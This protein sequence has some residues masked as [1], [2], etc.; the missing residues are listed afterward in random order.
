MR[1]LL[2][3]DDVPSYLDPGAKEMLSR[4]R[5]TAREAEL[6]RCSFIQDGAHLTWFTWTGTRIHHTLIAI[7]IQLRRF[8]VQNE[9]GIA[10]TFEK[11]NEQAVRGC[12]RDALTTHLDAQMLAKQFANPVCEKYEPYLSEDLQCYVYGQNH[13]D[14]DGAL[15]EIEKTVRMA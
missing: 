14:L 4:A 12:Y 2:F 15:Q 7:G 3:R 5:T 13:L 9:N 6:D 8:I 1:S 11:T 10:L